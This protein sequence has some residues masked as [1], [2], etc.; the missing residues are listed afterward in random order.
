MADNTCQRLS[1]AGG[2]QPDPLAWFGGMID[3]C[4]DYA[5]A[6]RARGGR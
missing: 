6:A 5:E 1:A 4:Y 3:H 2:E